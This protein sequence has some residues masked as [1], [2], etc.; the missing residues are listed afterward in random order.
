MDRME[1]Q[2]T[3]TDEA[4]RTLL[5]RTAI[6]Q[7]S[8][9]SLQSSVTSVQTGLSSLQG[10]VNTLQGTVNTLQESVATLQVDVAGMKGSLS[11]HA[12]KAEVEM[13]RTEFYKVME[14]QTWKIIIA[15]TAICSG[16][17]TA[18]Y[19]IARNVH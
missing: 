14:A 1:P 15:M 13:V 10:T 3:S 19:F 4:L 18:V 6:L 9:E 5:A 11:H 16:L 7:A 2:N 12:T 8:N 17:T